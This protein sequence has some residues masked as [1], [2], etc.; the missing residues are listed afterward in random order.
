MKRRSGGIGVRIGCRPLD[1]ATAEHPDSG[2][3]V[4]W[5]LERLERRP[6][7]FGVEIWTGERRLFAR[8]LPETPL[9]DG[10]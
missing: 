7:A 8:M 6:D 10:E 4:R 1:V 3:A 9:E 2:R 5:A